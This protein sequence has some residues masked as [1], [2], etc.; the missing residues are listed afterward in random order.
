MQVL[1]VHTV[2]HEGGIILFVIDYLFFCAWSTVMDLLLQAQR[3]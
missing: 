3:D 1:C 2:A